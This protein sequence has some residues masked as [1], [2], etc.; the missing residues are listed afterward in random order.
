MRIALFLVGM[1]SLVVIAG[2]AQPVHA[3]MSGDESKVAPSGDADYAAGRAAFDR[4]AWP[5]VIANL[6]KVVARRPWHDNAHAMLGYAYRRQGQWDQAFEHY[7]QALAHNPRHRGA[8]EYLAEAYLQ[9]NRPAEAYAAAVKLG[10]VCRFV[11]MA[12]DNQGWKTGCEEFETLRTAF[13]AR[14]LEL[15]PIDKRR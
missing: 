9:L 15:E 14:G 11:V 7:R 12:F 13:A 4:E 3:V 2:H 10:E 8:L 5:E 1:V 6:R